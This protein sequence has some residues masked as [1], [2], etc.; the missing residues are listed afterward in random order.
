LSRVD[1]ALNHLLLRSDRRPT[2]GA[3][4]SEEGL[5]PDG[6]A[7]YPRTPKPSMEAL[8][9]EFVQQ[10]IGEIERLSDLLDMDLSDWDKEFRCML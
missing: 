9:G 5:P 1:L 10:A 2:W 8:P 4:G 3:D 7:A 6:K